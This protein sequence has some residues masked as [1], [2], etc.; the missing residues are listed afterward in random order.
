LFVLLILAVVLVWSAAFVVPDQKLHIVACD[1]GQGDGILLYLGQAQIL[2]DGGPN[3][4]IVGCLERHMPFWDRRIE[5]VVLTHPQSDHY[6]GLINVF[7]NYEVGP[8]LHLR[9]T[10]ALLAMEC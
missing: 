5:L 3:G 2:V 4:S 6:G 10:V 8:C 9:L 7:E 1:V